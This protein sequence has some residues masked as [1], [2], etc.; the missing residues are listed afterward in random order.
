MA[1]EPNS[2]PRL[3]QAPYNEPENFTSTW[4][5][6]MDAIE[7]GSGGGGEGGAFAS[8]LQSGRIIA[9]AVPVNDGL[10]F[11]ADTPSLAIVLPAGTQWVQEGVEYSIDEDLAIPGVQANFSGW[12]K[13]AYDVEDDNWTLTHYV[14]RPAIGTGVIK[15]T[16]DADSVS[17]VDVSPSQSDTIPTV[18]L[19]QKQLLAL[20]GDGSDE[21]EP[22]GGGG[23]GDYVSRTQF[24]ALKAEVEELTKAV[25]ALQRAQGG[26]TPRQI[27]LIGRTELL[28]AEHNRLGSGVVR[29]FP[30]IAQV[31]NS[32]HVQP[33]RV[34]MKQQMPDG[35]LQRAH[36]VGGNWSPNSKERKF[37]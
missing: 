1:L 30:G 4:D 35:T 19:L 8:F 20:A 9:Q 17:A 3:T 16:S 5:A 6:T 36:Y 29:Q 21:E 12:V 34:G 23:T 14:T 37:E 18:G 31:L 7:A 27:R 25:A 33:G 10:R 13:P 2:L 22:G 11:M 24:N 28:R 15:V 32:A 26:D